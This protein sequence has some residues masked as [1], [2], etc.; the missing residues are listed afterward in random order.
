MHDAFKDENIK[1]ILTTLGGFN[2]N[3]LLR[4]LDYDLIK[5]KPKI[6]CGYSDITALQNAIY[7]KTKMV[8]YSS[9]HFSMFGMLKGLEYTIHHFKK[10]LMGNDLIDVLPSESWSDDRWF[11]DQEKR[12]FITNNGYLT[13]NEGDAEGTI[14]GGNLCTFQ[15][16]HGTEYM[17]ELSSAIIFIEDC[18]ESNET[19]VQNFDRYLQSL[20]HQPQFEGVKGI[21]I[22]RFE[23]ASDMT[24]KKLTTIIKTKKELSAIPIIANVDF[25]HT[26]P[27][28]TFPIGGK[29]SLHAHKNEVKLRILEH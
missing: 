12:E 10:C 7:S 18:V 20:I 3:Q 16:L 1:A 24:D 28:I 6:L 22:G 4:Y 29:A 17:P 2:S 9:P 25:G 5:S 21:V 26:T 15:L 19:F 13:I 27:Q 23:R 8:T 11:E 14:I